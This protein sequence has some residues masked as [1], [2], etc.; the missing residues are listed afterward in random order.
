MYNS[1]G[2]SNM[3]YYVGLFL[4][5]ILWEPVNFFISPVGMA[6]SRKYEREADIYSLG[7]LKTSK[8]LS[9]ALKKMAKENLS[10]LKPHPLYV[11]F[12][13]SHPP[14]LERIEYLEAREP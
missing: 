2:F 6:I 14:L 4:V 1:F 9:T 10:N 8:P 5:G 13:Y 3:P 7:V 12:N 11:C